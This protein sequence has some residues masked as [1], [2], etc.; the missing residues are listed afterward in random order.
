MSGEFLPSAEGRRII[1]E[2]LPNGE[3]LLMLARTG[4]HIL[5]PY[6]NLEHE[7]GV[8]YWSYACAINSSAYDDGSLVLAPSLRDN[9]LQALIGAAL[10]HDHNHSGGLVTDDINVKRASEFVSSN[11]TYQL[12]GSSFSYSILRPNIEVTEFLN[13]KFT[14]APK[15]FA[16]RCIR[17]ADLM[18]IY[19]VEGRNLL[20]NL[21]EELKIDI[22]DEKQRA[23]A[24]VKNA[25][26][27][28]SA[29]MFTSFGRAM[30]EQHLER[31]IRLFN[32]MVNGYFAQPYIQTLRNAMTGEILFK[33]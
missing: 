27:L 16:Q 28:R 12:F 21:F 33:Q 20:V 18:S 26:F 15:T 9:E 7:L 30:K 17:D 22:K 19:T 10:F 14:R 13:G 4:T 32:D 11:A 29:E 31:S 25:E 24:L 3:E 5:N 23:V 1:R 8:V 6:H 2:L